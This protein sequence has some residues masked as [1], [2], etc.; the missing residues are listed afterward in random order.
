M[1]E[2]YL[3]TIQPFSMDE[4]TKIDDV[5]QDKAYQDFL[6]CRYRYSTRGI[7]LPSMLKDYMILGVRPNE[8]R[9]CKKEMIPSSSATL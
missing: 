8:L 6:D 7:E 5:R 3:V 2:N 4:Q 9:D 1:S